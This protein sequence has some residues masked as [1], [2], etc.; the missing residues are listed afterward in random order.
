MYASYYCQGVV[1]DSPNPNAAQLWIEHLVSDEAALAF[2]EGGAIPARFP[3]LVENGTITEEM[4]A[5]LPPADLIADVSFMTA[6]QTDA[7]NAA[8]VEN[9]GPMVLG[10]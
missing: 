1:A 2:L 9:W 8:L 10:E 7:A 4:Q 3:T 5:N 6:E